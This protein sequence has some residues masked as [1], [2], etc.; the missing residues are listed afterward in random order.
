M[1]ED[2]YAA[3]MGEPMLPPEQQAALAKRLRRQS[4]LSGMAAMSGDRA[5]APWGLKAYGSA[6]DQATEM[7]RRRQVEQERQRRAQA[8]ADTKNY[9]DLSLKQARELAEMQDRRMRELSAQDNATRLAVEGLRQQ[10]DW[11]IAN[12]RED[13]DKGRN[14]TQG[15][16]KDL[17]ER[18]QRRTDLAT[19]LD[20]FKDEYQQIWG[21]GPQSK[22]PQTFARYGVVNPLADEAHQKRVK[23]ATQWYADF[24]MKF[25]AQERNRLFGATLTPSE[26]KAWDEAL[27]IH[28]GMDA[29]EV[30]TRLANFQDAYSKALMRRTRGLASEGFRRNSIAELAGLQPEEYETYLGVE[31]AAPKG[32]TTRSRTR[33]RGSVPL[34]EMSEEEL[35]MLYDQ[36][37]LGEAE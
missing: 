28:P 25:S 12:L 15:L 33:A 20:T 9:R 24:K 11:D 35:M 1:D 34:N 30:R 21:S 31:D 3:L 22:L 23:D 10:M 8:D 18:G 36:A 13:G 29:D 5:L 14:L 32:P 2:I 19:S 6:E 37:G 27:L 16:M 7:G 4:L 17:Q 26:E